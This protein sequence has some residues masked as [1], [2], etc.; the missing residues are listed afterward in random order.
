MSMVEIESAPAFDDELASDYALA[1]RAA[2]GEREAFAVLYRRH[3]RRVYGVCLRLTANAADA[4]DLRQE[5]FL[6]LWGKIGSFRGEAAFSSWLYRFTVNQVLMHW[7]KRRKRPEEALGEGKLSMQVE[8]GTKDPKQMPITDRI[9]IER[10]IAQLA[11]GH[12]KVF[13]LHDVEGYEHKEV[14]QMLGITEGTSKSQLHNARLKLRG[15]IG[16]QAAL[17]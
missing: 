12:R 3:F 6:H 14:A 17:N 4:E 10:A 8:P 1:G 16:Q 2:A 15:L 11:P 13:R 5:V 9:A 7:R